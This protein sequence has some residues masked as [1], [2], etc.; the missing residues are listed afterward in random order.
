M[1]INTILNDFTMK[2]DSKG[3]KFEIIDFSLHPTYILMKHQ[4]FTIYIAAFEQLFFN[5]KKSEMDIDNFF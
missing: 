2:N 1:N 3:T 4:N 5:T